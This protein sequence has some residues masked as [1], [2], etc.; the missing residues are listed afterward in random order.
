MLPITGR[1]WDFRDKE[2]LLCFYPERFH[3]LLDTLQTGSSIVRCFISLY[4]LFLETKLTGQFFLSQ[5]GSY[6]GFDK[7]GWQLF[8]R[9]DLHRFV[10]L[11]L[12]A[13]IFPKVCL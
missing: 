6:A 7:Y 5:T 11:F 13:F 10:P 9:G 8:E 4:L 1:D 3:D 12:Q 2:L